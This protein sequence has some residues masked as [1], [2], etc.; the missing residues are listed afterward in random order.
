MKLL[1]PCRKLRRQFWKKNKVDPSIFSQ[2]NQSFLS[3]V[4]WF[5]IGSKI[6]VQSSALEKDH[7]CQF[8]FIHMHIQL[9]FY[10][11]Y[12]VVN[13]ISINNMA[14]G[15]VEFLKGGYKIQ[16]IFCLRINIPKKKYRI[17]S[18]GLTASCQKVPKFDFQSQ[19][20][21]S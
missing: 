5:S 21:I 17:F 3:D 9:I 18:F 15:V 14:L 11:I 16:N 4:K 7:L 19:F 6:G 2:S 10:V 12:D 13:N 1:R 20:S 8:T